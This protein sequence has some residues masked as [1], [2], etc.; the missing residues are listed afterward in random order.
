MSSWRFPEADFGMMALSAN[1]SF[2]LPLAKSGHGLEQQSAKWESNRS[3]REMSGKQQLNRFTRR[4]E[5]TSGSLKRC[6]VVHGGEPL[7]CMK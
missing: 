4:A 5:E 7:G 2:W 6:R 1:V 3:K